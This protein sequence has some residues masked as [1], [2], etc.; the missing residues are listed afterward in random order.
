MLILTFSFFEY[1]T[2]VFCAT[3]YKISIK[4]FY[5]QKIIVI[6]IIIIIIIIII[7]IIIFSSHKHLFSFL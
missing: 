4:Y 2:E 3:F 1:F 7:V 6:V 5:S